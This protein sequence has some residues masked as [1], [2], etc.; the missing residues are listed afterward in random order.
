MI[1]TLSILDMKNNNYPRILF[2][3]EYP[4]VFDKI[5][6]PYKS[7]TTFDQTFD[8]TFFVNNGGNRGN[9]VWQESVFRIFN[10]N[11]LKSRRV[12]FEYLYDNQKKIDDEFDF[13]VI[14]LACW[15]NNRPFRPN[16]FISKLKF[17]KSK[18][19]CLGNGCIKNG[20]INSNPNL[21][22][23]F[24]HPSVVES[25]RWMFDNAE[26][27]SVRGE[28][29]MS[30]LKC[31]FNIDSVALGCP[32]A[33]AF[34][35]SINNIS[36]K[37]FKDS[38]LASADYISKYDGVNFPALYN[39]FNKF[40][41]SSYFCQSSFQFSEGSNIEFPKNTK[42]NQIGNVKINECDGS[43]KNYP[44]EIKAIDKIYAP[45]NIDNWRGVLSMHD[46]YIGTRLHCAMLSL[47]AGVFPF[48]FYDDE[49]PLEVA[50][51]IGMPHM[52]SGSN[53][54]FKLEEIFSK[55]NLKN[56]QQKY[57]ESY[58]IFRKTISQTGLVL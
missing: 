18:V 38:L 51:L 11:H 22:K 40:K 12:T 58:N 30:T 4:D 45:N 31:L 8:P 5:K 24:F 21:S 32:S 48:I 39:E 44:F 17:K 47:Q 15:I 1:W 41:S 2:I 14:N 25:L 37:P 19:I 35:D 54:S 26:V 7:E 23:D 50:N 20:Y 46:Y 29:T 52:N 16:N 49:R 10:Y 28:S 3:G 57:K 34:P 33:Y 9:L 36:L 13:I 43:L 27:F 6:S 56:F 55:K 53:D 42:L